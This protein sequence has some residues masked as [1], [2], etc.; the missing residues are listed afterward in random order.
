MLSPSYLDGMSAAGTYIEI[1]S[2]VF[3]VSGDNKKTF[4]PFKKGVVMYK[5][6]IF[7]KTESDLS[8]S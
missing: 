6:N 8:G 1:R 5:R 7:K 4:K 2:S 3:S